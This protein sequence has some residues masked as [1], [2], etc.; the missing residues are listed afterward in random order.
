MVFLV[1]GQASAH[2]PCRQ[3]YRY[4][5]IFESQKNHT[6]FAFCSH[7]YLDENPFNLSNRE[8][9]F[10]VRLEGFPHVFV[11]ID[12]KNEKIIKEGAKNALNLKILL[13]IMLLLF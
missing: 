7:S 11:K 2:I 10:I 5:T 6:I 1:Y 4:K 3:S 8:F 12:E 9:F 13:P